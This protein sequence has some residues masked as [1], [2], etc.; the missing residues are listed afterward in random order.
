M[1]MA[2]WNGMKDMVVPIDKAGRIV[3]PKEVR[4]E[5]AISPGDCF[6]ISVQGEEVTLRPDRDRAGFMR[7][8]HA[9]VFSAGGAD[10]LDNQIVENIRG[11][12]RDCT[13]PDVARGLPRHKRD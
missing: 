3:L 5:L 10:L 7:R 9:L 8:G 12:E 13:K 11:S 1:V 6:K 2:F 4:D